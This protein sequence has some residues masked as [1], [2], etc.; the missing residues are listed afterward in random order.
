M[1]YNEAASTDLCAVFDLI[2]GAA[3]RN[4]LQ[5]SD[6]P[7]IVYVISDME[8]NSGADYDTVLHEEI[9]ARYIRYGYKI[10]QVV[11]WNV[12]ARREQFPVKFNDKGVALVSG[13]SPSLFSLMMQGDVDPYRMMLKIV[14][15]D[16]Y[17]PICA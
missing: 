4:H 11:Y 12:C 2:L 13:S 16:R 6:L 14:E 5:Q 7:D 8:F 17:K 9:K 3:V 1:S 15:S 10:P